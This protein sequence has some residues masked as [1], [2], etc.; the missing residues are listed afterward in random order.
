M[1]TTHDI[2]ILPMDEHNLRLV[3]NVHP[4][5]WVNPGPKPLYDLVVIGAGTAGL[6]AAMGAAGLGARVA[7]VERHLM[8]G[9]CLNVGCVPSKALIACARRASN[10]SAAMEQV[11]RV[12][13]EISPHDS[14]ARFRDA[15][16]DVFLGEG[17]F[18]GR[19]SA[20]VDGVTL[21][22][23]RA[24]IATGARPATPPIAGIEN[25]GFLTNETVF[26]LTELPRRLAV[27]GAG[28]IGCELAQA[29]SRFGSKV[30][31]LEIA[32]R[33]LGKEEPDA[34]RIVQ[35]HLESEGVKFVLNCMIQGAS[36]SGGERTLAYSAEG[37]PAEINVDAILVGGG[38][39][40]NVEGAGLDAAGVAFDPRK[41]V[42]VDDFLRTTNARIYAAGDVCMDWKF[43]HAA[44]FA[45]RIV[46]QN[47]L[48]SVGPL[49][50]RK[51]SAL[52]MPWATYTDPEIGH[53]GL[54]EHDAAARGI[55]VDA[56]VQPFSG[57]DRAIIDGAD[58]GFA[59]VLVRKGTDKIVG[60]TIVAPHAGDFISE[61]T[62]AMTN[63]VGLRGI[64]STIHPYPT[65][66]DAIRKL[67][68]QFNRTRLTPF[69]KRVLRFL[70]SLPK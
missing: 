31:V 68:D 57:V 38:R 45:A 15:G 11:R 47:A 69:S 58:E 42:L 21:R 6:V 64:A 1:A 59:K 39:M 2:T 17:R 67:G 9:D 27:I 18:T 46:I 32:S 63:G 50:K 26:E 40:P 41:G 36:A 56:Y 52:T 53:V 30:T 66:A 22:F 51:L 4:P 23:R 29:F 33:V 61:I 35:R 25:A 65:Y 43:T 8:G 62:L 55:S 60:A 28:P 70:L 10:F 34:A 19:D 44:D 49:G 12:R 20:E 37:R 7:L 16:V 3:N 5:D 13:A 14:A 24:C 54:Y 48:F